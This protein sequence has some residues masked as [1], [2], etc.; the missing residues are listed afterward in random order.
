[1]SFVRLLLPLPHS[2]HGSDQDLL[3]ITFQLHLK[4]ISKHRRTKLK[5]DHGKVKDL[6]VAETVQ[7]MID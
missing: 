4:T 1:M 6:D 3:M 5:F 7:A 2:K